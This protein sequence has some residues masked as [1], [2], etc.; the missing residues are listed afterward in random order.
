MDP[1]D[2]GSNGIILPI[3]GGWVEKKLRRSVSGRSR[4]RGLEEQKHIHRLVESILRGDDY[5]ILRTPLL[6]PTP[7]AKYIMEEICTRKPLWLSD[8]ESRNL[9]DTNLVN[10]TEAELRRFFSTLWRT[11]RLAAWDFELYVQPDGRVVILDFD[12]FKTQIDEHFFDYACF[13]R[14]FRL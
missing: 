5:K 13:P 9:F 4:G 11:H 10:D 12:K 6:H 8:V 3:G 14:N 1:I 7:G 2:T